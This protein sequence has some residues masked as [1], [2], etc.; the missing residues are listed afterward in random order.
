[1][2]KGEF[3]H[4]V[5]EKGRAAIP[6]KIRSELGSTSVFLTKGIEKCIYGF[7]ISEWNNAFNS[8]T[9]HSSVFNKEDRQIRRRFIAPAV[10]IELDK[11]GRVLIP[12]SL[13]EYA[14]IKKECVIVGMGEYFEI[15][16]K[17]LYL[18]ELDETEDK[19]IEALEKLGERLSN[20]RE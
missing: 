3:T 9:K 19:S 15:W 1:M 5:D 20:K 16:D 6:A 12:P 17:E 4:F 11:N 2:L 7:S 14:M 8:I 18:M 13:R 10:E